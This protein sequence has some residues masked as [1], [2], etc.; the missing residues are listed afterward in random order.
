MED[1]KSINFLID[2]ANGIE[3]VICN[4]SIL[5]YPVH[6]HISVYTIGLVTDGYVDVTINSD[7]QRYQKGDILVIPPYLPHSILATNKYSMLSLCISRQ[8]LESVEY[9]SIKETIIKMLS[10]ITSLDNLY[11]YINDIFQILHDLS[12]NKGDKHTPMMDIVSVV[13][14]QLEL[15]P[16]EK[17]SIDEMAQLAFVSKY[18]FIRNFK[19]EVGLTPHQFQLQNRIRKAQGLLHHTDRITE[20]ALDTGFCDQSHFIRQFEKIVRLTPSKYILACNM[21][22]THTD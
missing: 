6:N 17:I 12:L 1:Y 4:Q 22:G 5:S 3:L 21:L 16:E 8:T 15:F 19:Q 13:R 18:H 10:F 2:K 9:I 20:V 14:E 7:L 11:L